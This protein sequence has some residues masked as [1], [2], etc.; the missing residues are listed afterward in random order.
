MELIDHTEQPLRYGTDGNN[1]SVRTNESLTIGKTNV[2]YE[3]RISNGRCREGGTYR[4]QRTNKTNQR[5]RKVKTNQTH[6]IKGM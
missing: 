6:N 5:Y 4:T 1:S 2:T 3:T